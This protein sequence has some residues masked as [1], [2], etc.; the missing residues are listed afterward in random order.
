MIESKEE[1]LEESVHSFIKSI[2]HRATTRNVRK[3]HNLPS[4]THNS[5][6]FYL[7]ERILNL[8]TGNRRYKWH[9]DETYNVVPYLES[10]RRIILLLLNVS[11]ILLTTCSI[12]TM[13]VPLTYFDK[14]D[15]TSAKPYIIQ[16]TG[17]T[18]K[19]DFTS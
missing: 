6:F 1:I 13:I 14:S 3:S 2:I 18:L 19:I 16:E 7:I 11:G 8:F 5:G 4:L 15:I 9:L 10:H 12:L 17:K